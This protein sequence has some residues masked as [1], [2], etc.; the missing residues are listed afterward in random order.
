MTRYE[1]LIVPRDEDE[2]DDGEMAK[3]WRAAEKAGF[4]PEPDCRRWRPIQRRLILE[5]GALRP[6]ALF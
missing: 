3:A 1:L 5:R 6:L 2:H 4:D